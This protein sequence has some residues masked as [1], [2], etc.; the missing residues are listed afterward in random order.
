MAVSNFKLRLFFFKWKFIFCW[1]A[2]GFIINVSLRTPGYIL[3]LPPTPE[4]PFAKV[5]LPICLSL[6]PRDTAVSLDAAWWLT[7]ETPACIS[8]L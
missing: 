1:K 3:S 8:E 4:S 7:I 6:V 2:K 5:N